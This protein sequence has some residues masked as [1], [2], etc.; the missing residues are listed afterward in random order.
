MHSIVLLLAMSGTGDACCPP[1]PTCCAP[2]P[3]CCPKV[4]CC[5]KPACDPCHSDPCCK[6]SL[7]AR[8]KHRRSGCCDPCGNGTVVE[9]AATNGAAPAPAPMPKAAPAPAPAPAPAK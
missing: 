4:S 5:P 1:K 8:L 9:G 7:F 2:K 3:A 6:P